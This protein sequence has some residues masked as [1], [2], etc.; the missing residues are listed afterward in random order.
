ME[1]N[2]E[3]EDCLKSALLADEVIS[4][5]LKE[6]AQQF[7]GSVL[8]GHEVEG[9]RQFSSLYE[10][11]EKA[12]EGNLEARA[13]VMANVRSDV[14]ERVF[15]DGF[16]CP[17]VPLDVLPSGTLGQFGQPY[18]QVQ[19]NALR[20]ANHPT[21]ISRTHAELNNCFKLET[22]NRLGL[23][24]D[25]SFVVF[26]LAEDLPEYGFFTQSMS[27]AVQVTTGE[28][29]HLT[30]ETAFIAGK[31]EAGRYEAPE[32]VREVYRRLVGV[33][34]SGLSPAEIIDRPLL[35][36]NDLLPN[37][38]VDVVKLYD[39]IDG[40]FYGSEKPRQD[41][42]EHKADCL[43]RATSLARLCQKISAELIKAHDQ[44]GSPLEAVKALANLS[45]KYTLEQAGKDTSIDPLVFGPMAAAHIMRARITFEMGLLNMAELEMRQAQKFAVSSSCPGLVLDARN[46]QTGAELQSAGP[47]DKYGPLTFYCP[48][49]HR[50]TRSP[51]RL[52]D[53]CTVCQISVKC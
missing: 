25:Y 41:Y 43:E 30:T 21:I 51:N 23:M 22:S 7:I 10:A 37:G 33:D 42:L 2:S 28:G 47:E 11:I 44:I 32:K 35:I 50:N 46:H 48:K 8:V 20:L 6:E 38:A 5:E 13:M 34:I 29:D 16:V 19:A 49:G 53:K 36:A 18:R 52:L 40:T 45:Q 31:T 39:D 4:P 14:L 24:K 3:K 12:D 1:R 9:E 15:K 17:K 27:L 26:S